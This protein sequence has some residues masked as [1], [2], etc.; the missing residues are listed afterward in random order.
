MTALVLQ[1]KVNKIKEVR[2]KEATI[3]QKGRQE[4][5]PKALFYLCNMLRNQLLEFLRSRFNLDDD[6]APYDE[7]V[8]GI[9]KGVVFKGPN[10][11]ILFFAI[12]ICSIG[13]NVNS[14]AVIIGAMLI[15]PIMGPIIGL[16]LGAGINDIPLI[17]KS[18][19]NLAIA[20][21]ISILASFLYFIVTPLDEPQSELFNRTKP[22]LWDVGVAFFGGLAG[23]VAGTRQEKSNVIP[24][25][26]IAT[27]LMPPLC[28]AGYGLANGEWLFFFGAFYLFIIN[29][30]YIALST[31]LIVRFLKFPS[32]SF[33]D[34]KVRK[35]TRNIITSAILLTVVPS[36]IL[37]YSMVTDLYFQRNAHAFIEKEL[38]FPGTFVSG[39]RIAEE[40]KRIE[41]GIIG[42]P[43]PNEMIRMAEAKLPDYGLKGTQL[44]ITQGRMEEGNKAN[45]EIFQL[46]TL[47][48]GKERALDSLQR[49]LERRSFTEVQSSELFQEIRA[50]YAPQLCGLFLQTG[51][52]WSDSSLSQA[53]TTT[54]VWLQLS[55]PLPVTDSLRLVRWLP[56][57]L[58]TPKV[59]M[60]QEIKTKNGEL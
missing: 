23:I 36:L 19:K 34:P 28:T 43:V 16:G 6:R 32:R 49:I 17:R 4:T 1:S 47:L 20:V 54:V 59:W 12:F 37:A 52:T 15:S 45:E 55:E 57:R 51:E 33:V 60:H 2:P 22:T 56:L 7:I 10:L 58:G 5:Y 3:D 26:A 50:G 21:G 42:G 46:K 38:S 35:W 18:L 40:P 30:V 25:V 53:D 44:S 14:T 41:V 27:A 31:L 11:W 13:L 29:C 48:L 8:V 9:S 24:G 39:T